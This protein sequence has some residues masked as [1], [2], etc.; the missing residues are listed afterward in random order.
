MNKFIALG[1]SLINVSHIKRI[2]FETKSNSNS[3]STILV[4]FDLQNDSENSVFGPEYPPYSMAREDID[5][6]L[7]SDSVVVEI[8]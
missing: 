1:Q 4:F 8:G 3:E 5:R 7:S 6:A 2:R